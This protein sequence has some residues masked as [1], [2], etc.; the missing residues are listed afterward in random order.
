M[1]VLLKILFAQ[2]NTRA[3]T[4]HAL[5]RVSSLLFPNEFAYMHNPIA[6]FVRERVR[7]INKEINIY[8]GRLKEEDSAEILTVKWTSQ[9]E[10]NKQPRA[11]AAGR[12]SL[13]LAPPPMQASKQMTVRHVLIIMWRIDQ[14]HIYIA[15]SSSF[16]HCS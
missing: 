3:L 15:G 16:D 6:L 11:A 14:I 9:Y 1:Y 5:A 10:S 4:T 12:L 2:E 7:K 13:L 8:G